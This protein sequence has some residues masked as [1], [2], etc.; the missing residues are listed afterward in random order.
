VAS[1]LWASASRD[2]VSDQELDRVDENRQ[3][4]P[5][6][7]YN[8]KADALRAQI[9]LFGV[10]IAESQQTETDAHWAD[11]LS[12]SGGAAAHRVI[13]WCRA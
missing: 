9:T 13:I 8:L 3:L 1:V 7:A 5:G 10:T 11:I 2:Q 4:F 6:V 12:V